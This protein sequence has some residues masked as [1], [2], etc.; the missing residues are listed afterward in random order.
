MTAVFVCALTLVTVACGRRLQPTNDENRLKPSVRSSDDESLMA[1]MMETLIASSKSLVNSQEPEHTEPTHSR[2]EVAYDEEWFADNCKK[3]KSVKTAYYDENPW[4]AGKKCEVPYSGAPGLVEF[5]GKEVGG[6]KE[7]CEA[8]CMET[9]DADKGNTYCCEWDANKG[10][11][12]SVVQS[13]L[14]IEDSKKGN[15]YNRLINSEQKYA[16]FVK[17][18]KVSDTV[19]AGDVIDAEMDDVEESQQT[20]RKLVEQVNHMSIEG[21]LRHLLSFYICMRWVPDAQFMTLA[22]HEFENVDLD[23]QTLKAGKEMTKEELFATYVNFDAVPMKCSSGMSV[24]DTEQID[25]LLKQLSED[26]SQIHEAYQFAKDVASETFNFVGNVKWSG[27]ADATERRMGND[28]EIDEMATKARSVLPWDGFIRPSQQFTWG[29]NFKWGP[30]VSSPDNL[31]FVC[32]GPR[33]SSFPHKR[34]QGGHFIADMNMAGCNGLWDLSDVT[35]HVARI[36]RLFA[37]ET[38]L[39]ENLKK[40]LKAVFLETFVDMNKNFEQ[41]LIGKFFSQRQDS[42]ETIPE[43]LL[44]K[45]PIPIDEEDLEGRDLANRTALVHT[46]YARAGRLI[47]GAHTKWIV[48]DASH[49]GSPASGL[50]SSFFNSP[51][52]YQEWF[53]AGTFGDPTKPECKTYDQTT[54]CQR[55]V[56]AVRTHPWRCLTR[57]G[58]SV[59]QI[60]AAV[61]NQEAPLSSGYEALKTLETENGRTKETIV[62]KRGV[63]VVGKDVSNSSRIADVD[64][65]RQLSGGDKVFQ[66]ETSD[67]DKMGFVLRN[68]YKVQERRGHL[69]TYISNGGVFPKDSESLDAEQE[70]MR[71]VHLKMFGGQETH[72]PE[73]RFGPLMT[74]SDVIP[75]GNNVAAHEV[76]YFVT[77]PCESDDFSSVSEYERLS[78]KR[79]SDYMLS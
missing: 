57:M 36:R 53:K 50:S 62:R 73:D 70:R 31:F 38:C 24:Q 5:P 55:C 77:C 17:S 63:C 76:D 69:A 52:A 29:A 58:L 1:S 41:K 74:F 10:G 30:H 19:Q 71:I 39:T 16:K 22:K 47:A 54:G 6:S 65:F 9:A 40:K 32:F 11:K 14:S 79:M 2:P 18:Q 4:R 44:P 48:C 21:I 46:K 35:K 51:Q 37:P 20:M 75:E 26:G 56:F 33:V 34:D 28:A 45:S 12:C 78:T 23:Q 42:V 13:F 49:P 43:E 15:W 3:P 60:L 25:I 7:G 59:Q 8:K 66:L 61:K 27:S 64:K 67:V 68:R 72:F